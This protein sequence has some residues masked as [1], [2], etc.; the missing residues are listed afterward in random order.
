MQWHLDQTHKCLDIMHMHNPNKNL[1]KIYSWIPG[2]AE[3]YQYNVKMA[4]EGV[5]HLY[6]E[7]CEENCN[8][9]WSWWFDGDYGYISFERAIDIMLFKLIKFKGI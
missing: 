3:K 6:C 2:E 5:P 1:N 4:D 8:G 7:W 9:K